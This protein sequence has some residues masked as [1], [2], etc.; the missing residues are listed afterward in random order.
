M[1]HIFSVGL[2]L[3]MLASALSLDAQSSTPA[4]KAQPA[5]AAKS[6]QTAAERT[7]GNPDTRFVMGAAEGGMAE[8]ELGQ[9][10]ADKASNSKV[11]EFGQRMVA[12]HTKA[13]DELKALATS[14]H[15]MLPT[16]VSPRSKATKDRLSKLSGQS[17]DRAYMA[18]MVKGHLSASMDF[19]K[20]ATSGHDPQIKEWATRTL[21]TV[22]DH[23]TAA[24]EI[25]K[26]LG[27]ARTTQ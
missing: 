27:S 1:R 10:A 3:A 13:G 16:S 6:A 14:K 20:E 24:R 25:Q 4:S 18:E 17:F 11:K 26:E 15:I 7:A 5:A 9:L 12:D 22:D 21:I 2:G 19:R 8:I 23:L